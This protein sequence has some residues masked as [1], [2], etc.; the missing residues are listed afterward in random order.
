MN[1]IELIVAAFYIIIVL[2]IAMLSY[3]L[4]KQ[5]KEQIKPKEQV[6]KEVSLDTYDQTAKLK[7]RIAS[8]ENQI[9]VFDDLCHELTKANNKYLEEFENYVRLSGGN[10]TQSNNIEQ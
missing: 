5:R 9:M 4:L 3:V 7:A 2:C 8:L 1:S 6:T 10:K